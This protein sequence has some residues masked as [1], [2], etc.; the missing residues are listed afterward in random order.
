MQK[1]RKEKEEKDSSKINQHVYRSLPSSDKKIKYLSSSSGELIFLDKTLPSGNWLLTHELSLYGGK[2]RDEM[3]K[4]NSIE[5]KGRKC[6]SC[7]KF[8]KY[9]CPEKD[10]SKFNTFFCGVECFKNR[11]K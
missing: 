4:K 8:G 1:Q 3:E 2:R 6:F 7:G 5:E 11:K 9:R 10:K